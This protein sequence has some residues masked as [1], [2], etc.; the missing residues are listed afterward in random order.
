MIEQ[1]V[2]HTI[3]ASVDLK[4]LVESRGVTL[5]KNGKGWFGLCPFHDDKNP[6]LSVNPSTN[7]WQCFGCG[8][9]GDV[10]RF[11]ELFDKVDFTE[12]VKRL[13][14]NGI[15][16]NTPT[17]SLDPPKSLAVKEKKLLARVVAYYQHTFTVDSR[18]IDYLKNERGI[19]DIASLKDFGAGFANGTLR[20][21]LPADDDVINSLK[22]IGILNAKG[23]ETFY[24]CVTFPLHDQTGAIVNL[25]GRSINPPG[26]SGVTHLYLPGSRSGLVNRQ[27]VKRSQTIILT[28]SIID[29]LTLY[30]QGFKNVM[31]IYGVNGLLDEHLSFFTGRIKEAFLVFDADDAGIKASESVSLRLKEKGI[32][33]Y[34]VA[35][36]VKDVNVYFKRQTPEQFEG[37]LKTAN[38]KSLE[39]SDKIHARKQ[40]LYKEIEHGFIVG[41]GDRQYQIKGIQRGDTQLKVTIKASADVTGNLPF[42]LSK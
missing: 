32:T 21:I 27:A 25:Y 2:I 6:S 1:E 10:I 18:G 9:A 42:E 11:V 40:S 31:P 38:P 33:A 29:A 39:C 13:S 19:T 17:P 24:N 26:E 30:D 28:E 23:H 22:T 16:R 4:S 7:L 3:K 36:P 34:P 8:A 20:D 5:K 35:L 37:L 12:A 14:D 41:F 15:K